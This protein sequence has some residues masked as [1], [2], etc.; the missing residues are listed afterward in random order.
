MRTFEWVE[1]AIVTAAVLGPVIA[2]RRLKR[3]RAVPVLLAAVLVQWFVEGYR[4]QLLP[5]HLTAVGLA[6]GDVLWVDRMVTGFPRFRRAVLG[7]LGLL[8]LAVLPTA[9]PIP[10]IPPPSG[11]FEVGTSTFGVVDRDREDPYPVPT[12]EQAASESEEDTDVVRNP[13]R[14]V[15]QAWYPAEPVDGADPIV[16]N[17][18]WDVVGPAM[19][20][21][22]GFPWFFLDHAADVPSHSFADATPLSGRLPVVLYS[23]GWRGFRT[24]AL[25]QMEE[26]ASH[27]YVVIALDHPSIAV[28]TRL[29]DGEVV[30][31][32]ERAL[33]SGDD[34]D[35]G[36]R[37]EALETM[38]ET[39][40]EDLRTVV[41]ELEKGSSGAFGELADHVDLDAIGLLGHSVGGGAVVRFCLDDDRCSSVAGLDPVV[42]AIPDRLVARELEVPSIFIRSDDWRGTPNDRRLRGMA[43]RSPSVSWWVGI[44]GAGHNDFVLTPF[45]SPYADEIGLRG[46]VDVDVVEDALDAYLV[47]FFDRTLLGLGGAALDAPAPPEVDLEPLP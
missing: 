26:L 15:A 36:D 39:Q 40:A 23:H 42:D 47:A 33:P 19:S 21:A 27:G 7:P 4:W 6:V 34:V 14:L 32:D 9:L 5:L 2:G 8:M 38:V 11:P 35:E 16:W 17:E 46:S 44:E 24:I 22:L 3:G 41:D 1:F 20:R 45:F 30:P 31:F 18:D 12:E 29:P 43:E 25:N 28:T 10:R 13:R 37:A